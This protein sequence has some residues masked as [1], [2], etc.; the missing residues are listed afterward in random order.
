MPFRE[1]QLMFAMVK[2][3]I[4]QRNKENSSDDK[5]E[6]KSIDSKSMETNTEESKALF[7]QFMGTK[8]SR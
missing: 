4:N 1:K 2:Y 8:A 3:D 6:N 5:N 7:Q